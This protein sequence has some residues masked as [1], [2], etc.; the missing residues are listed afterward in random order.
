[1]W[2]SKKEAMC[3]IQAQGQLKSDLFMGTY[4]GNIWHFQ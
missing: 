3:L 4:K 2:G 1:M